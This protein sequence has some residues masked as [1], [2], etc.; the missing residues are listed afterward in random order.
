MGLKPLI[1]DVYYA[2]L[3]VSGY[4]IY[5]LSNGGF[6]RSGFVLG[7]KLVA[8]FVSISDLT[9]VSASLARSFSSE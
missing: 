2:R 5:L 4:R 6:F 8:F 7:L 9:V 1:C 3:S